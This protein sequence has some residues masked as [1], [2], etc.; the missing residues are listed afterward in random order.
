MLLD[1][2]NMNSKKKVDKKVNKGRKKLLFFTLLLGLIIFLLLVF[3]TELFH[4]SQIDISGNKKITTD[5][6]IKALGN[7]NGE[8]IFKINTKE[9][10]NKINKHPYIKSSNIKRR[11]PNKLMVQ[12]DEREERAAIVYASSYVYIDE[13]GFVLKMEPN[14]NDGELPII[15]GISIDNPNLGEKINGPNED[16]IERMLEFIDVCVKL[17]LNNKITQLD[18]ED[19]ENVTIEINNGIVVAFGPLDNVKYKLSYID[20]ILKDVEQKNILCKYIYFNRG[21]NPV[22]VID[23]N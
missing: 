18:L 10:M 15:K 23:N 11:I 21:E 2:V 17:K 4:I 13:E 20:K 9:L 22:I 6:I 14:I 3:K 8:N 1:G 12:I 5:S 7:P 19:M 16:T